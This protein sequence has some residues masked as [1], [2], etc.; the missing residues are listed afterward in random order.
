M[1]AV[2]VKPTPKRRRRLPWIVALVVLVV[3]VAGGAIW[4]NV[5]A[6]APTNAS[7]TLAVFLPTASV[8]HSG[9]AYA[10]AASGAIVQ[11]GDGVRTDSK[12]RA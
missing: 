9:G 6:A 1:P 8:A 3:L 12:G 2:A 11:P 5:S 4:L 7:A 10:P